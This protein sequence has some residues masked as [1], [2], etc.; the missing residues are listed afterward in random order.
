MTYNID[1]LT[2]VHNN[3]VLENGE[4]EPE[5][6]EASCNATTDRPLLFSNLDILLN[7]TIIYD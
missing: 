6:R 4:M 7:S 2:A 1:K 5:K 3:I